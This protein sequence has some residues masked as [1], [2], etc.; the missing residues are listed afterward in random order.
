MKQIISKHRGLKQHSLCALGIQ[1]QLSWVFWLRVSVGVPC[2]LKAKLMLVAI[3]RIWFF[4]SFWA[5]G[6][7]FS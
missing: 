5:E 7:S 1:V 6:L 3:V 2:Y 4:V